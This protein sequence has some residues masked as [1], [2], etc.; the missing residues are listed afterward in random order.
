MHGSL[1]RMA[2]TGRGVAG[3]VCA[4]GLV[5]ACAGVALASQPTPGARYKG[6]TDEKTPASFRVSGSGKKIPSYRFYF[7]YR[8]SNGT[9][10]PTAFGANK[11][12][13]PIPVTK[14]G[15]FALR[16]TVR[17]PSIG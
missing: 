13:K 8:C 4:Y 9:Q 6:Q 5:L 15:T 3:A 7:S 14:N 10:G 2:R 12:T 1:R 17:Q 16:E 11:Q